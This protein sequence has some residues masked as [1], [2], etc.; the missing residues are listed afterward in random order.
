ME[1]G[2]L[3]RS[4]LDGWGLKY[5]HNDKK[6]LDQCLEA[7]CLS[8]SFPNYELFYKFRQS[9]S[10]DQESEW[11]VLLID[12]KVL[13]ELDCAFCQQNAAS[14]AVRDIKLDE[15]KKPEALKGM[16]ED[17]QDIKRSD[18]QIPEYFPTNPQAE[19]LVF[20]EIPIEYINK[21]HFWNETVKENWRS[22]F[23]GPYS[24]DK[25][26]VSQ[27]YF[28]YRRDSD[29]WK[30]KKFNDNNIIPSYFSSDNDD[31]F[32]NSESESDGSLDNSDNV[33]DDIPF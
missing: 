12:V 1:Y 3:G 26:I 18:L 4:I 2:L 11:V 13:W 14:N 29:V 31:Y 21:I 8:I 6:R 25:Y 32:L 15:R 16:F 22:K 5:K 33:E 7:I 10:A 23:T 9:K 20:R 28:E 17:F 24:S 19:V 27:E 30:K